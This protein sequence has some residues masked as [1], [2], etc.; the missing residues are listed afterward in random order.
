M[1]RNIN[2]RTDEIHRR[3]IEI[4]EYVIETGCTVRQ[5]AK[6]FGVSKSTIHRDLT[7]TLIAM[8]EYSLHDNAAVIIS[9]NKAERHVRGGQATKARWR[10]F[11]KDGK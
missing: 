6:R 11:S 2:K 8:H 3:A 10:D 7:K 9:V 4:A 1:N 5:A